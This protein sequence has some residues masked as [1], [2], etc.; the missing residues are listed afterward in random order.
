MEKM[1]APPSSIL[2]P[3]DIGVSVRIAGYR[4]GGGVELG[5]PINLFKSTDKLAT[6][7]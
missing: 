2:L 1:K 5:V 7:W 4:E 6:N 3:M